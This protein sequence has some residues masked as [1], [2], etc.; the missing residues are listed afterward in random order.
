MNLPIYGYIYKFENTKTGRIYIGQTINPL[1]ERYKGGVTKAWIKER[2]DKENQ[3]FKEEL[4]NEDIKVTE[5][6][7]IACCEYHLNI[8]EV[9]WINYYDSYNNGYNNTQ[10]NHIT[11][12]GIEEFNK[13]L[14]EN[15]LKFVD[16]KLIKVK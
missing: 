10:G 7:D 12:D 5:L 9:Y 3:K 4:I 15:G 2:L 6:F 14:E 13:I 1:K 16:G 11:N 8:L